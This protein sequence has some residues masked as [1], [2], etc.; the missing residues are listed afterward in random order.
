M[1]E[2]ADLN[3]DELER[4]GRRRLIGAI[5]LALV[6]AVVPMLLRAS[7]GRWARTCRSASRRSTKANT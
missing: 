6:A 3:L 1:A 7:R 2:P 5:V 4:R